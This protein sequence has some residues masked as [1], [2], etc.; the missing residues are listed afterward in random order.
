MAASD[1]CDI[2]LRRMFFDQ[3]AEENDLS[4]EYTLENM[5]QVYLKDRA[6]LDVLRKQISRKACIN[7]ILVI[8]HTGVGKSSIVNLLMKRE[9]AAVNNN[10]VGCTFESKAYQVV[11]E[12]GFYEIIDTVGLNENTQG[13]VPLN[14]ALREL[15]RFIRKNKRGFSCILFVMRQGRI[16]NM[17]E[18][19]YRLFYGA[20]LKMVVP[21]ILFVNHCEDDE[22]MNQWIIDQNNSNMLQSYGFRA[23]VCGTTKNVTE[24]SANYLPALRDKTYDRLWKEIQTKSLETPITIEPNLNL[25]K[26]VWNTVCKYCRIPPKFISERFAEF[27]VELQRMGIDEETIQ[28]IT[29][30]LS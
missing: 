15:T 6:H 25:F 21:A 14:R 19:N 20:L 23:I 10:A 18:Q 9:E 30:I 29:R 12:D 2:N 3:L 13:T 28:E 4:R 5:L 16:D 24:R 22:P 8:G 11:F 27:I 1:E 26:T 17:F 7:R